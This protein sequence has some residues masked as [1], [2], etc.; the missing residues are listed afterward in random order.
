MT[1]SVKYNNRHRKYK[2]ISKKNMVGGGYIEI[3]P[4]IVSK[5][6]D[7]LYQTRN[8]LEIS[9]RSYSYYTK[10][11]FS[12]NMTQISNLASYGV[13]P[14]LDGVFIEK[15]QPYVI[16]L[17][18]YYYVTILFSQLFSQNKNIF[19]F[20]KQRSNIDLI[21]K[22]DIVF[23]I[24]TEYYL[25][26][27]IQFMDNIMIILN[28]KSNMVIKFKF[29]STNA[30]PILTI[31]DI[32][33]VNEQNDQTNGTLDISNTIEQLTHNKLNSVRTIPEKYTN[34]LRKK[35]L[36][37]L[38]NA[39]S[40]IQRIILKQSSSA[41]VQWIMFDIIDGTYLLDK[42]HGNDFFHKIEEYINSNFIIILSSIE[43]VI[44]KALDTSSSSSKNTNQLS[45]T[46]FIENPIPTALNIYLS[47]PES[48]PIKL[49]NLLLSLDMLVP[50]QTSKDT[51][52]FNPQKSLRDM[53]NTL[54]EFCKTNKI[55]NPIVVFFDKG[56]FLK[57]NAMYK[58]KTKVRTLKQ[59]I[60]TNVDDNISTTLQLLL[61]GS[62]LQITQNGVKERVKIHNYFWNNR[63]YL[64]GPRDTLLSIE[65][66]FLQSDI[67]PFPNAENITNCYSEMMEV[68][69]D[70][71]DLF[72]PSMAGK[73]ISKT[74]NK[75]L[76]GLNER[77]VLIDDIKHL[78][79]K[80]RL[81]ISTRS[82]SEKYKDTL[83]NI[84]SKSVSLKNIIQ[85]FVKSVIYQ[86]VVI[87][88][89]TT[90]IINRI[91]TRCFLYYVVGHNFTEDK[92]INIMPRDFRDDK[93]LSYMLYLEEGYDK[94]S[95]LDMLSCSTNMTKQYRDISIAYDTIVETIL[96][97]LKN[98]SQR[99]GML[100]S[101]DSSTTTV[102][103]SNEGF[104]TLWIS[105][106]EIEKCFTTFETVMKSF[107]KLNLPSD[108]Y[109]QENIESIIDSI[110]WD[111]DASDTYTF[112]RL[113]TSFVDKNI[114][115]QLEL[116]F[117]MK[118]LQYIFL[119]Y[120][121]TGKY[122]A[123]YNVDITKMDMNEPMES[124]ATFLS[125]KLYNYFLKSLNLFTFSINWFK[126]VCCKQIQMLITKLTG[127]ITVYDIHELFKTDTMI[128][129]SYLI[130]RYYLVNII[131]SNI[132]VCQLSNELQSM[133]ALLA[134]TES[135]LKQY[136][137]STKMLLSNDTNTK[138]NDTNTESTRTTR[139]PEPEST[140]TSSSELAFNVIVQ[141]NV[142][143]ETGDK[144]DTST[145]NGKLTGVKVPN[146][147][148]L[149]GCKK[150][151]LGLKW[152]KLK[153][154]TNA[155]VGK[156]IQIVTNKVGRIFEPNLSLI[157]DDLDAINKETG[158]IVMKAF[159]V[160][161]YQILISIPE[162][163]MENGEN[164]GL[165]VDKF[166]LKLTEMGNSNTNKD[167]SKNDK[168]V[169]DILNSGDAYDTL[170]VVLSSF[171][172]WDTLM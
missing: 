163:N 52:R 53:K 94:H 43:P 22:D 33:I 123:F 172:T 89:I 156:S 113:V 47:T 68:L 14:G 41:L 166:I 30:D 21:D 19:L 72:Y 13:N 97:Q 131:L 61:S 143:K 151:A 71:V 142:S 24:D 78:I 44:L 124:F 5:T 27:S 49:D 74:Y 20:K 139:A 39:T 144:P 73:E 70:L 31:L 62:E 135:D 95:Y 84:R 85:E 117:T 125:P 98:M 4:S 17:V 77:N 145:S 37:I 45:N 167:F 99:M 154:S 80:E 134:P 138:S 55:D 46:K 69:Q 103:V 150:L 87:E 66:E 165:I 161:E 126:Y 122:I 168:G 93:T 91:Q 2:N 65:T 86:L 152:D 141:V 132:D 96:S 76:Q 40:F 6:K 100:I 57:F 67:K 15:F 54:L 81:S 129:Q 149:L 127:N 26:A 79:D 157:K 106:Q 10:I 108:Y 148:T 119:I 170:T 171:N 102:N 160:P 107:I 83:S 75:Y 18:M 29:T 12:S 51:T 28:T 82:I 42:K 3:S 56:L 88:R 128:K 159:K 112:S 146:I 140:K 9:D 16:Y 59:A 169:L 147:D 101:N 109:S 1:K 8:Y 136:T 63:W 35:T 121:Y 164:L 50:T 158:E 36:S 38:K 118:T 130:L 110:L 155:M 48:S 7:V 64:T 105:N 116:L 11:S 25:Y 153:H 32:Y 104:D 162:F 92:Q 137:H 23:S 133:I 34:E 120:K 58:K 60:E 90:K 111:M 114:W 115:V